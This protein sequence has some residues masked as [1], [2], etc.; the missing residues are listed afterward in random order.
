V[1]YADTQEYNA[2][3]D[4]SEDSSNISAKATSVYSTDV[5]ASNAPMAS[6]A[7]AGFAMKD[8]NLIQIARGH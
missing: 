4:G 5:A 7:K 2:W 3:S 8:E 1:F 6:P